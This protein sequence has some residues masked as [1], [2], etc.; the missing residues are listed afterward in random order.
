[1]LAVV[2][3]FGQMLFVNGARSEPHPAQTLKK[4][5]K[6]QLA[7]EHSTPPMPSPA[8]NSV[9]SHRA[10]LLRKPA[11]E[12]LAQTKSVPKLEKDVLKGTSD[13]LNSTD[14]ALRV[15]ASSFADITNASDVKQGLPL[16]DPRMAPGASLVEEALDEIES[17]AKQQAALRK[18]REAFDEAISASETAKE[19]AQKLAEEVVTGAEDIADP[20]ADDADSVAA[21]KGG[22]GGLSSALAARRKKW[23]Q[24]DVARTVGSFLVGGVFS[25]LVP[26]MLACSWSSCG[27][28]VCA[29]RMPKAFNKFCGLCVFSMRSRSSSRADLLPPVA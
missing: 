1:M 24:S 9:T 12:A 23:Y 28:G 26:A 3:L 2:A 25:R 10:A 14:Q 13:V 22:S 16:G 20:D 29:P 11:V 7:D 15:A 27:S 5:N 8:P 17:L 18:A 6:V 19:Q 4:D 21:G